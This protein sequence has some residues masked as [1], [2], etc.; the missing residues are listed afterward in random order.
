VKFNVFGFGAPPH[1]NNAVYQALCNM[2][3]MLISKLHYR[4][5]HYRN[6]QF[7]LSSIGS[8]QIQGERTRKSR[9]D[10]LQGHLVDLIIVDT[11]DGEEVLGLDLEDRE[12]SIPTD[13][14]YCDGLEYDN[15]LKIAEAVLEKDGV[16]AFIRPLFSFAYDDLLDTAISKWR[17]QFQVL[18]QHYLIWYNVP[19]NNTGLKTSKINLIHWTNI[20]DPVHMIEDS[21]HP[22]Y[23]DDTLKTLFLMRS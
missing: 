4:T 20:A 9:M 14:N 13:F 6:I 8:M 3:S 12:K 7:L 10:R 18:I 19:L 1:L 22:M 16:I 15:V 17:N 11:L 2:S 23:K 5:F 21:Q